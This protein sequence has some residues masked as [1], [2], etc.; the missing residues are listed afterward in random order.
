MSN[1]RC[2]SISPNFIIS[3]QEESLETAQVLFI[4]P[5]IAFL[6]L[7]EII[8]SKIY[9]TRLLWLVGGEGQWLNVPSEARSKL[10]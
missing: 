4:T 8:R 5:T 9:R 6:V 2:G 3:L 1:V 10:K 7:I